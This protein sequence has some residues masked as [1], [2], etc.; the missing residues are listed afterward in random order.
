MFD[1][2]NVDMPAYW[3]RVVEA[4]NHCDEPVVIELNQ[5]R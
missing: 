5:M 4:A 3:E 2:E 1:T